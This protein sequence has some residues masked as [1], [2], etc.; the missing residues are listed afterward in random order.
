MKLK[1]Y[2]S[3][4]ENKRAEFIFNLIAPI[5]SKMNHQLGVNYSKVIEVLKSKISIE[6]MKVLDIGSGTGVWSSVYKDGGAGEVTGIDFADKM[7]QESRNNFPE[8]NFMTADAEN[9]HQ[10]KDNSFDIVTASFVIHGVTQERREKMLSEMKRVSKRYIVLH[11]FIGRTPYF[12]RILEFLER[13]DYK[14][15]KQNICNELK[16]Q[17]TKVESVKVKYGSGLYIVEI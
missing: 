4:D 6:N 12:I 7:I 3:K 14:H 5:Y 15:F 2:F 11:D 8:I 13:S 16:N 17:F 10:I 9:L 1:H